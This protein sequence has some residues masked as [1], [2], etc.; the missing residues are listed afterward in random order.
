M[1]MIMW[2]RRGMGTRRRRIFTR[3]I[4]ITTIFWLFPIFFGANFLVN[5]SYHERRL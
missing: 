1:P 2:T 4:F 5:A 3:R